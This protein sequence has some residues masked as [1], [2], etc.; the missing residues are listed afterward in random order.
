MAVDPVPVAVES[1]LIAVDSVPEAKAS[2]PAPPVVPGPH[3]VLLVPAARPGL[4]GVAT[5]STH[6]D[7]CANAGT[8]SR[9]QLRKPD[10]EAIS[11]QDLAELIPRGTRDSMKNPTA[12]H[13][14]R[15]DPPSASPNPSPILASLLTDFQHNIC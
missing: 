1:W 15:G 3:A 12:T 9:D 6:R 8:V 13:N 5:C 14:R 7:P 2:V 11:R 10:R 4:A